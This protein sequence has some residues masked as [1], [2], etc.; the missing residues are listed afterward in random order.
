MCACV[1]MFDA[2]LSSFVHPCGDVYIITVS[3]AVQGIFKPNLVTELQFNY[4]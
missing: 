1:Y 2:C 3:T 4:Q